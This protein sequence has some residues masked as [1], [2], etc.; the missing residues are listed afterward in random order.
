MQSTLQH[1]FNKR[2]FVQHTN[3]RGHPLS[4][5][6]HI[7]WFS[8]IPSPLVHFKTIEWCHKNN[9][10]KCFPWPLPSPLEDMYFMDGPIHIIILLLVVNLIK[11]LKS[12]IYWVVS[13][14]YIYNR[15]KLDT[16]SKKA[17]F[18]GSCKYSSS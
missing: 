14:L 5:Y 12:Y 1:M 17:Y 10:C 8:D 16:H 15:K 3:D 4:M 9:R 2:C 6:T 13:Y 11:A 18:V 7:W